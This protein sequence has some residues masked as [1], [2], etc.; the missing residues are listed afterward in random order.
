MDKKLIIMLLILALLGVTETKTK[1]KCYT[2]EDV[3]YLAKTINAEAGDVSYRC[4]KLVGV[5]VV[6]R[7]DHKLFPN[8][9]KEVVHSPSQYACVS[10][11]RFKEK[12]PKKIKKL[13]KSLLKKGGTS[14]F[15]NNLVYQANFVQGTSVYEKVDG[16]YFCLR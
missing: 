9:I 1:A 8:T 14:E 6:K 12:P 13:A 2:K 5:V 15:P 7:R 3:K 16:V 10:S 4:Q 11:D